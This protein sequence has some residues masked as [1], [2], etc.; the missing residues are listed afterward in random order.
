MNKIKK[1]VSLLILL[2]IA[3]VAEAHPALVDS[4]HLLDGILHFFSSIDHLLTF[5]AVAV[6]MLYLRRR[7][8][9]QHDY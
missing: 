5:V 8:G 9:N 1:I 7:L 3:T 2:V 4:P 6:G